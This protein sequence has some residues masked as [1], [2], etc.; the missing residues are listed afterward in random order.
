MPSDIVLNENSL[1]VIGEKIEFKKDEKPSAKSTVVVDPK[2]GNL[3]LGK[4]GTDGDLL[5]H[6]KTGKRTVEISAEKNKPREDRTIYING[7]T[8]SIEI[9]SPRKHSSGVFPK[10]TFTPALIEC[11][12]DRGTSKFKISSN[13]TVFSTKVAVIAGSM[14]TIA[15]DITINAKSRDGSPKTVNVHRDIVTLKAEV[16]ALKAQ[17][18]ILTRSRR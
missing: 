7:Q 16:K 8:P 12:A 17:I 5:I 11:K 10:M 18:A 2:N 13:G 1:E 6:G 9:K 4:N 15:K 3:E 14:I